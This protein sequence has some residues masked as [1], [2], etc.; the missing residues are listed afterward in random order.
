MSYFQVAPR[1]PLDG[2]NDGRL[3]PAAGGFH[4]WLGQ[5][6]PDEIKNDQDLVWFLLPL[7]LDKILPRIKQL[8]PEFEVC[9]TDIMFARRHPDLRRKKLP[10][11]SSATAGEKAL[12]NERDRILKDVVRPVVESYVKGLLLDLK[13][14]RDDGC[15]PLALQDLTNFLVFLQ[16]PQ[17][18][19]RDGTLEPAEAEDVNRARRFVE[20]EARTLGVLAEAY[21]ELGCPAS[22]VKA[23]KEQVERLPW[24]ADQAMQAARNQLLGALQGSLNRLGAE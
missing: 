4:G 6:S 21:G 16:N 1:S 23:L 19:K 2:W 20:R 3:R 24:P 15:K 8:I 17:K 13:R 10:S 18:K 12:L 22:Q 7:C 14:K 9:L 11:R 5:S